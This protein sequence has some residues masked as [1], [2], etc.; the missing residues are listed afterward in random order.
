MKK[1]KRDKGRKEEEDYLEASSLS[2]WKS[3]GRKGSPGWI[4]V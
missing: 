2:R 3:G 1:K 4:V